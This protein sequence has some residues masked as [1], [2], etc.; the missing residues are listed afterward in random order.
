MFC[1]AKSGNFIWVREMRA[2][3]GT[4]LELLA[5]KALSLLGLL[6]SSGKP[7]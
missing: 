1:F 3:P 7:S 6:S 2:F 5:K 4:F